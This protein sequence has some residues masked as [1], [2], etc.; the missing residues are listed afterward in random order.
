MKNLFYTLL[1]LVGA[2]C[3]GGGAWA[4]TSDG[5]FA[6]SLYENDVNTRELKPEAKE[7]AYEDW[8]KAVE[9]IHAAHEADARAEAEAAMQ[10][11]STPSPAITTNTGTNKIV[12]QAK[13]TASAAMTGIEKLYTKAK[14]AMSDAGQRRTA[15]R[16]STVGVESSLKDV[17]RYLDDAVSR[18]DSLSA[19]EGKAVKQK[20]SEMRRQFNDLYVGGKSLFARV[21]DSDRE[22]NQL[23]NSCLEQFNALDEK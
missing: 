15:D 4:F 8:T 7:A 5:D 22:L 6:W 11:T 13:D 10:G 1:G 19:D 23:K 2:V 20:A 18:F 17:K 16:D 3:V 9:L 12:G 14:D 21:L